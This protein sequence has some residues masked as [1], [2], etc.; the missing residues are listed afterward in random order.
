MTPSG[1]WNGIRIH[2]KGA[3]AET[4]RYQGLEVSLLVSGDATEVIHHR[5]QAGANWAL[6]P[7]DGW[8][9][10][11]FL[12]VLSGRLQLELD[13]QTVELRAGDSLSALPVQHHTI[14]TA[15]EDTEFLY[16]SSQ[17]VFH[18]YSRFVSELADMTV[19]IEQKDGYTADHCHRIMQYAMRVGKAMHLSAQELYEVNLGGFM[20]DI[21][22]VRVPPEILNKPGRLTD[23]EFEAMKLHTVYGRQMLEETGLEFL[24]GPAVIVEQ[25]HER[26]DGRGYPHGLSGSAIRIG[27]AIVA[28][29]DAFD[30]MTTDRVYQ[31][32]RSADE[33]LTEISNNRG[34]RY[35]PDVVDAFLA[36]AEEID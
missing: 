8:Q 10:L 36:I 27:A 16:V 18:G 7:Q 5:L 31:K 26:F 21:G 24:Q 3:A 20:H 29:V 15:L 17:P 4:V 19:A 6:V 13:G 25:H 9:A 14:F 23:A 32:A 33:A 1:R 22:K 12:F 30:A 34:T 28:V 2:P 11:E 35:H